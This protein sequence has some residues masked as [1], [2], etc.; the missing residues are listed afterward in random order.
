MAKK[1]HRFIW[2]FVIGFGFLSGI[3]T[4]IGIDPESLL[5]TALGSAVTAQYSQ[6]LQS[7]R[8]SFS[9]LH[10]SSSSR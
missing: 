3:W 8:S 10:L 9:C 5:I 7:A 1:V 6:T 4:A 2:Q